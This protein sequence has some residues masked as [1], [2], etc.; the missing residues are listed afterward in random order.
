MPHTTFGRI[1]P[2]I[3]KSPKLST[4]ILSLELTNDWFYHL[5][6]CFCPLG[7]EQAIFYPAAFDPYAIRVLENNIRQLIPVPMQEADRFACNAIVAGTSIIMNEGCP[8]VREELE[9]LAP[10]CLRTPLSEFLRAGGSAKCL[11]LIIG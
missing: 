6:T 9:S 4:E 5:D 3:K 1:L 7:E 8:K 11:A 10:P 2:L